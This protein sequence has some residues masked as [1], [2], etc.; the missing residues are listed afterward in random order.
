VP[1]QITPGALSAMGI[2]VLAGR[3]FTSGDG[4]AAPLVAIVSRKFADANWPARDPLGK[5]FRLGGDEPFMTVVGVTGDLRSRGFDDVPEPTMYFPYAQSAISAYGAPRQ[6]KVVIRVDRNPAA[7][8][9]PLRSIV[10]S[11]D[12]SA[13]V[14]D[15]RTLDD[16]VG[17]SVSNRRFTTALLAG[18]ALLA[19]A[20]AGIGTY[21]V[22]SYG[23]EQR[24]F[25]IGVRKAL[26]AA[27]H[28]VMVLIMSEAMRVS[29]IGIAVGLVATAGVGRAIRSLLVDVPALDPISL[30]ITAVLLAGVAAVA[31]LLPARR[32]LNVSAAEALKA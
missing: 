7:L 11:L 19:L 8:A 13:P 2:P 5:R 24:G 27:D 32:A 21:G 18:F 10:H 17:T 4:P 9:A 31:A 12:Q 25:E 16:V 28:A 6:L 29:L 14:S 15:V 22:V 26:G 3:D 1:Q 23:V 20:L 30:T